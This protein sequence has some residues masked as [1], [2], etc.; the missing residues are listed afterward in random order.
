M[1]GKLLILLYV[2]ALQIPKISIQWNLE[3][4]KNR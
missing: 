2:I 1:K 4:N 3:W